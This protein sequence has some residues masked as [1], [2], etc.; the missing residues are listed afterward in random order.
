MK[1]LLILMLIAMIFLVLLSSC[2]KSGAP[3]C[4]DTDVKKLVVDISNG[5]LKNQLLLKV[6]GSSSVV[7]G[8]PTYEEWNKLK[9]K[10]KSIKEVV[11]NIDKATAEMGIALSGI[12]INEKND[13]IKKCQCG[14]ELTFSNGKTHSI[15]YSAQYTEDGQVYVEVYGL[16]K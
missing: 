9:D 7:Q 14:G 8:N 13:K 2:G 4:T 11:D 12:R 10:D 6:I 1:N 3:N 16:N 15:E 5:E